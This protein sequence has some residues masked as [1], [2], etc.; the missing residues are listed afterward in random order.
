MPIFCSFATSKILSER[1][2]GLQG[3]FTVLEEEST[4]LLKL[5]SPLGAVSVH[6]TAYNANHCL[7][8]TV[9]C[10]DHCS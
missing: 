9:T 3:A 2:P 6:V 1:F 4:T 7:V 8:R 5:A 10:K